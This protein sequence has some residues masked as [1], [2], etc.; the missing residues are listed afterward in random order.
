MTKPNLNVIE[1]RIK[2]LEFQMNDVVEKLDIIRT[3]ELPH[4]QAS[5]QSLKTEIRV[6]AGLN[7]GA[8]IVGLL[9]VKLFNI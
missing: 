3:N 2:D 6:W 7:I 4:I 1:Q 9:V 8:I 5:I